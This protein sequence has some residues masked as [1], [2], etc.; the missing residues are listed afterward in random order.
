MAAIGSIA[1]SLQTAVGQD[2]EDSALL[3]RL[4][5]GGLVLLFRHGKTRPDSE[6]PDAVS[7]RYALEGS[8]K[9]RQA[10]YFD[11][12]R[13]RNLS[14]E[15]RAELRQVAEAM[16]EIGLVIGKALSSPMCR[17]RET[18]WLLVGQVTPA[19]ALIG[20]DNEERRRLVSTVPVDGGNRVLV[21]HGYIV[22]S[23]VPKPERPD[24]R[25]QI[26]RGYAHVLE[27]L[28]DGKFRILAEL[29]PDDWT[30]LAAIK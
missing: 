15:G 14:D 6:Q 9:E 10:A 23:I 30:R 17:T 4:Q 20:P 24:A 1:L 25:G 13:Q 7:G 16:R 12:D 3:A 28:G 22:G 29:G 27:P 26:V 2:L 8:A 19:D 18:A 11:C 21:S 5:S